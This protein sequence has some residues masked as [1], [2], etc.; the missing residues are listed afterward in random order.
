MGDLIDR[1]AAIDRIAR[2]EGAY[3]VESM[4]GLAIIALERQKAVYAAPV[5]RARWEYHRPPYPMPDYDE[6][7]A[8][9]LSQGRGYGYDVTSRYCPNCGALMDADAPER[10]GEGLRG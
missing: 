6:C 4:R 3:S 1:G 2:A 7:S 8:C 10:G 9:H 5:V